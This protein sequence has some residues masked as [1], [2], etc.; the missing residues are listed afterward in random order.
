MIHRS[1]RDATLLLTID[2][3]DRRNAVDLEALE[4]L[5]SAFGE[6]D[7]DVRAVV[8]TG[9]G[10]H[11]CSG[12]DLGAVKDR[13]FAR[14]VRAT[15]EAV[16]AAPVPTIA[17]VDGFALGAGTQL[18]CACD[19]RVASASARFGIPAARLGICVDEWTVRRVARLLGPSLARSVLLAAETV[20]VAQART[21]GFVHREGDL[22]DALS[23][24]AELAALAPLSIAGHKAALEAADGPAGSDE[25]ETA[26][27]RAWSSDDFAEGVS[28]FAERRV[29]HFHGR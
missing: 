28:A 3:Q 21:A 25:V 20:D 18:A 6:L 29:P 9:A 4:G 16:V 26:I 17:A 22:D 2:R 5:R 8:L 10:G 24:A 23:W 14:A 7:D 15:L 1:R 19:L 11:F 13:D 12:A 27:E